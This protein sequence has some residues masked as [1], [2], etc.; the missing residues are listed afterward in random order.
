[1]V[2]ALLVTAAVVGV[3][4]INHRTSSG[5]TSEYVVALRPLRAGERIPPDA[6]GLVAVD[7][8]D[9]VAE[10]SFAEPTSL[11]GAVAIHP[12]DEGELIHAGDVLRGAPGESAESPEAYELSVAL[13]RDRALDGALQPGE[14]VDAVATY[15][16]GETARSL[17][18]AHDARVA[19]LAEG[20]EA[21]DTAGSVR[22]TLS[23]S[24]P[25]EVL[26][27]AHA[28]EVA[29]LRLVRS[30]RTSLDGGTTPTYDG[31]GPATSEGQ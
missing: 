18:V 12:V 24:S 22:L 13:D 19:A 5:P 11:D 21:L 15:G 7:L 17:I 3:L 26:R 14:R 4:A 25:S 9:A 8:P 23:L 1:M 29:G 10:V 2:G 27:T 20:G 6:L 16:T 31:P 30:T 28:A